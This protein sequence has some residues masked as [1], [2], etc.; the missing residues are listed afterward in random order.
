MCVFRWKERAKHT[1]ALCVRQPSCD[2]DRIE[3]V[4]TADARRYVWELRQPSSAL[5]TLKTETRNA[6]KTILIG[7][8]FVTWKKRVLYR[9]LASSGQ[10]GFDCAFGSARFFLPRCWMFFFPPRSLTSVTCCLCLAFCRVL[11]QGEVAVGTAAAGLAFLAKVRSRMVCHLTRA[12]SG[13]AFV[14]ILSFPLKGL[15]AFS[16]SCN[17]FFV[18]CLVPSDGPAVCVYRNEALECCKT[19]R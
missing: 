14:L 13:V 4:E 16:E 10:A 5:R 19:P 6:D 17:L 3:R 18:A 9:C 2:R 7:C 1:A 15:F 12:W 11:V 8:T